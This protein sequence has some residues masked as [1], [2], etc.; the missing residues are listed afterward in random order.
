MALSTSICQASDLILILIWCHGALLWW[1][2][3]SFLW[4]S[5]TLILITDYGWNC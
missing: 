1:R 3:S 5:T 2:T 4:W